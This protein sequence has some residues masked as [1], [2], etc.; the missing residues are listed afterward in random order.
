[1]VDRSG[2]LKAIFAFVFKLTELKILHGNGKL[3]SF[4]IPTRCWFF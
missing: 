2:K 3:D 1:M 4:Y